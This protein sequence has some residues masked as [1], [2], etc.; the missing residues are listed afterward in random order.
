MD[1][2]YNFFLGSSFRG[3]GL[4]LVRARAFISFSS[5]LIALFFCNIIFYNAIIDVSEYTQK[6]NLLVVHYLSTFSPKY[7]PL[8][9][10]H[11]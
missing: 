6:F 10:Y 9:L 7:H 1:F 8:V 2:I 11:V 3:S 4:E 5:L